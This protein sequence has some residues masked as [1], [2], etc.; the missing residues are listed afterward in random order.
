MENSDFPVKVLD[1][2]STGILTVYKPYSHLGLL[3][4]SSLMYVS[5][6]PGVTTYLRKASARKQ[7]K[8]V[9]KSKLEKRD[10]TEKEKVFFI[11]VLPEIRLR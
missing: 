5:R 10:N 1:K 7:P 9:G 11:I 3:F 6:K 8:Q 2:S 4:S